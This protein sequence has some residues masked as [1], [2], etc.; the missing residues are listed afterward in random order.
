MPEPVGKCLTLPVSLFF[1]SRA[2]RNVVRNELTGASFENI[3]IV[4][5]DPPL[6]GPRCALQRID[7][8]KGKIMKLS[9]ALIAQSAAVLIIACYPSMAQARTHHH[10]HHHFV[11]HHAMVAV[12]GGSAAYAVDLAAYDSDRTAYETSLGQ[13]SQQES[14]FNTQITSLNGDLAKYN[15]QCV[16]TPPTVDDFD[17]CQTQANAL[18]T[19]RAALDGQAPGLEAQRAKLAQ[20][21][22]DLDARKAALQQRADAINGHTTA[23]APS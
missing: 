3:G 11:R 18:K 16:T 15:S 22:A 9:A 14:A 13:Y 2:L 23:A 21:Q 6:V 19:R 10:H 5:Q 1:C 7:E 4:R 17:N 20:T 8:S 12:R